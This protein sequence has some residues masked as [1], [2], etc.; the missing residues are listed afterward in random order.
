VVVGST[1]DGGGSGWSYIV[2]FWLFCP[3]SSSG[4]CKLVLASC[5]VDEG[6]FLDTGLLIQCIMMADREKLVK[7][8]HFVNNVLREDLRILL[9][10]REKLYENIAALSQLK[11]III[12]ISEDPH[13]EGLRTQVDLGSNFYIQ[14]HVLVV[15]GNQVTATQGTMWR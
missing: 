6:I 14:A 10:D 1:G 13:E 11:Q 8:E 9:E 7:Y 12:C 3:P 2:L 15:Y 4:S 5:S